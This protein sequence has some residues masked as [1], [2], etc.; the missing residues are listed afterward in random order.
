MSAALTGEIVERSDASMAELLTIASDLVEWVGGRATYV[1]I[2]SNSVGVHVRTQADAELLA[3]LLSLGSVTDYPPD[4]GSHG[5]TVWASEWG[6]GLRISVYCAADLV[7]PVR[8]FP[9]A[10]PWFDLDDD[11]AEA[12]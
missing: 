5:F 2:G 1:A 7:R 10:E 12:A 6:P 4:A 11:G 9:P 3:R 8:A